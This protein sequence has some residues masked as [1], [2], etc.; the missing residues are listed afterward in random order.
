MLKTA[1]LLI[2]LAHGV[3]HILFLVPLL[4]IANWD[5]SSQSWLLGSE[6]PAKLVGGI[7]W[8][9]A[10]LGFTAAGVGMVSQQD[11][12]RSAAIVASV[13]SL[14][15]LIVFWKNP[16]SSSALFAGLVDLIVP[17]ALLVVHWPSIEMIGA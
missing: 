16:A 10:I 4:G 8:I 6:T 5:Q 13:V 3:G 11:W 14:I 12:W 2:V 17:V 1:L 7:L 9:V 15:G